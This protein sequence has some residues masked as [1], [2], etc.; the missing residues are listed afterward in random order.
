M[1]VEKGNE[2]VFDT[3]PAVHINGTQ[4]ISEK[5]LFRI[6]F[7]EVVTG[8]SEAKERCAIIISMET[9]KLLQKTLTEH[10]NHWEE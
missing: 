9:A 2:K 6:T 3:M 4:V 8:N 5:T 7:T 10:I 1:G